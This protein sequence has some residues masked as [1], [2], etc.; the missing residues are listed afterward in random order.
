MCYAA[1]SK[2]AGKTLDLPPELHQ[3]PPAWW[4]LYDS[5][6]SMHI[7][8]DQIMLAYGFESNAIMG[9]GGQ[10]KGDRCIAKGQLFG[11]T[12]TYS[13]SEGWVKVILHSGQ[14]DTT[15]VIPGASRPL[16]SG[17][18]ARRQGHKA[19][20]AGPNPAL[21][22]NGDENKFIPLVSDS[23][24]TLFAGTYVST[25][26]AIITNFAALLP[27]FDGSSQSKCVS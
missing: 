25:P 5:G 14:R 15:W 12:W 27:E 21:F 6:A 18:Q 4:M 17:V 7:I 26:F 24:G 13:P 8:L 23:E 11:T 22:L 20:E 1:Y 3:T 2:A 9:W 19:V 16:F 10:D